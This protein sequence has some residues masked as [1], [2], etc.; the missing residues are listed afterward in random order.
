MSKKIICVDCKKEFVLSDNEINF[1]KEK[2]LHEPKRC[3]DCRKA[4]KNFSNSN[5][6]ETKQYNYKKNNFGKLGSTIIAIVIA[7]FVS[8][9][10][11]FNT[12]INN[13]PTNNDSYYNNYYLKYNFRNNDYAENHFNKHRGDFNY[14]NVNEYIM[15]ANKVIE[16][17]NALKKKEQED[18]DQIFF[19]K[20]TNE[21]VFLSNDGYIRTYFRPKNGLVYFNKQ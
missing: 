11:Q 13:Q 5:N 10:S 20:E 6:N 8:I 16:N 15:G 9:W 19:I 14:Q 7:I 3:L 1:Y 4:K 2:N 21:I 18:D 12:P 17:P